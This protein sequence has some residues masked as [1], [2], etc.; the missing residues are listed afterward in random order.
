MT[1]VAVLGAG[2]VG[3][4]VA[5]RA[6][7]AGYHVTVYDPEPMRGS[8]WVAGGMLAPLTEGWPGEEDT[9]ALGVESARRWPGFAADVGCELMTTGTV[10][11]GVD[12]ADAGE[13]D[14]L[15]GWLAERGRT[16]ARLTRRELRRA[17]PALAPGIRAA[18]DVPG[19]H[20][21]DN[22]ALLA[23][24]AAQVG[25]IRR[26]P[27]TDL[28]SVAADQI[29]ICAGAASRGLVPGLPVR[30]VKGEILRLRVRNGALPPP[31]R[32]VRADHHG[33]QRP[34]GKAPLAP[35]RRRT[36]RRSSKPPA[37]DRSRR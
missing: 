17:E 29:V 28:G 35:P 9:L 1:S 5:F 15:Q 25:E 34:L 6:V 31:G 22:R 37:R 32:T 7:R 12:G 4:A 30:A 23:A 24:L 21:V 19:D 11:L 14:V 2:A 18:L 3:L 8:S 26:E 33:R 16:V 13:L 10:V 27:V 20:A 36:P